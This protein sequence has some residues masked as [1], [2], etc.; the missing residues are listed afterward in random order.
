MSPLI[1]AS[2]YYS[3][4]LTH[5]LFWYEYLNIK[6]YRRF[7]SPLVPRITSSFIFF[8]MFFPPFFHR[9]CFR[10]PSKSLQMRQYRYNR[11]SYD[12]AFRLDIL[13]FI[14]LLLRLN[15]IVSIE[16]SLPKIYKNHDAFT[17]RNKQGRRTLYYLK[18]APSLR[19]RSHQWA[20][21]VLI[22]IRDYDSRVSPS[23]FFSLVIFSSVC[24]FIYF[25]LI[26]VM[27]ISYT[28]F[29]EK[30]E[31]SRPW[32]KCSRRKSRVKSAVIERPD[33][34]QKFTIDFN[35]KLSRNLSLF[36][37]LSRRG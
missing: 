30:R 5:F 19:S 15:L 17:L 9:H 31:E 22:F 23:I 24:L 12:L 18:I 28:A 6:L 1:A 34:F 7:L 13:F 11:A 32:S 3:E 4:A 2:R 21:V 8:A 29:E 33:R 25:F 16:I 36:L 20:L 14:I 26:F 37:S 27:Y 10:D 35:L